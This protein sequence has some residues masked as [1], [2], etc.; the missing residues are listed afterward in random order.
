[1]EKCL[2]SKPQGIC[3]SLLYEELKP[4]FGMFPNDDNFLKNYI[5]DLNLFPFLSI[6]QTKSC[7]I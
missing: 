2:K 1:M 5:W 7:L 3:Y 6:N 4:I